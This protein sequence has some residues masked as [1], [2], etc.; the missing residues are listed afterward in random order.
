MQY[1]YLMLFFYG[2]VF[3]IGAAQA[4][5]GHAKLAGGKHLGYGIT[6]P[7]ESDEHGWKKAH[8]LLAFWGTLTTV[9]SIP[10]LIPLLNE[11]SSGEQPDAPTSVK[12]L[13]TVYGIALIAMIWWPFI[14][15]GRLKT[16]D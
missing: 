13:L 5:A 15:I 8:S 11:L 6:V 14:R 1:T 9:L 2:A 16:A 10:P 7:D 4:V 12:V 3:T